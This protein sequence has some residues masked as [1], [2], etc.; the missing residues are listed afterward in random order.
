MIFFDTK[1]MVFYDT[2]QVRNRDLTKSY[3][4]RNRQL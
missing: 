1:V 2:F 4:Q 3:Q